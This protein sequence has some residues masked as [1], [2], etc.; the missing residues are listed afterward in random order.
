MTMDQLLNVLV[1]ITLVEMMVAIGLGVAYAD[2]VAVARDWRLLAQAALANYVCVPAAALGLLLALEAKPMVAAGFL[3]AAV[4]PGAPYGPP[5]TAMAKGNAAVSVGLMVVLAA[6]SALVAPL[7]LRWLLPV[8]S[9]GD[10]LKVDAAKMVVTLLATQ[11][12]PLF[13]GL[14]VRHWRPSLAARLLKPANRLSAVLNVSVIGLILVVQFE[15]LMSIRPIGFAG[16]LALVLTA[17]TA[18]W[19]LG[20]P[21]SANRRAMAITTA[22]RNVGV[23]LVIATGSFPGTPAV[24]ATLAF[25]LFQTIVL[26]LVALSW[27]RLAPT[28]SGLAGES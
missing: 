25:A 3:V 9:G 27:G 2:L 8:V 18:G 6:S 10:S 12:L 5:C 19:L 23:A 16:M 15:T 1:T 26:A 22:V 20:M 14:A 11:L 24:T 13:A 21:G 4:C 28:L 7:L 17:L